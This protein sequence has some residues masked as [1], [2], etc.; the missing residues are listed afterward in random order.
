ML[1][2][3]ALKQD[4]RDMSEVEED[5]VPEVAIRRQVLFSCKT[6][7]WEQAWS[8]AL[9]FC[10]LS[11]SQILGLHTEMQV[12]FISKPANFILLNPGKFPRSTS[13]WND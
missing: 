10:L 8:G 3:R 1:S 4:V 13:T 7:F 11:F 9:V 6:L 5:M 12:C 2:I